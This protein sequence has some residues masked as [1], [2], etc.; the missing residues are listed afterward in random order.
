MLSAEK[1]AVLSNVE[2]DAPMGALMKRYWVPACLSEE[3]A[4]PDCDPVRATVL[5]ED[6]VIFRDTY[7]RLGALDEYCPHRGVSLALGRNEDCGLRCLYHG[8]KYDVDGRIL[9][10]PSEPP[11]SGI[12][13]RVSQRSYPTREAGG[14]VWTYLGTPEA[15]PAFQPPP[16]SGADSS[17]LCVAKVNIQANWAQ[18]IEG[19][20][21]SAH[22]SSL[23]STDIRPGEGER[24]TAGRNGSTR[25]SADMAPQL[26]VQRT[27]FGMRYVAIRRPIADADTHD[28]MRVTVFIAPFTVLIPPNASYNLAHMAVPRDDGNTS[29]YFVNFSDKGELD[30]ATSRRTLGVEPGIDVDADYRNMR[31]RGNH[32][33]QD[34]EA[35]R[36]GDFTGIKGILNQDIAMWESMGRRRTSDRT[37]E[38]LVSTDIAVVAFRRLMIET[39]EAVQEG[40]APLSV[41]GL[42]YDEMRSFEGIVPKGIDWRLLGVTEAERLQYQSA[43]VDGVP[44]ESAHAG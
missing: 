35:M 14:I 37:K 8:W 10:T 40:A 30:I 28:Y 17:R 7:G 39:A 22:S 36:R 3:V 16:W 24:T 27:G 12:A 29:V 25:P 21:D 38:N 43:T 2:G 20:I 44:G 15:M 11:S 19:N 13:Q 42:P 32:F 33:L 18:V 1:N 31:N 34:R 41:I 9:E 26:Q 23:H 4:A 6:L 5:G